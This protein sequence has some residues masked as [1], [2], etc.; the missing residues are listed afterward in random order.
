MFTSGELNKRNYRQQIKG[1]EL[2]FLNGKRTRINIQIFVRYPAVEL[3]LYNYLDFLK[4]S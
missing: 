3:K 2:L 1:K 4:G